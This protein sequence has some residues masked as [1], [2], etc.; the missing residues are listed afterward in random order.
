MTSSE[1]MIA[2]TAL[3]ATCAPN[4][5]P[6]VWFANECGFTPKAFPRTPWTRC[7]STVGI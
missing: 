2:I 3:R 4:V 7:A 6:T 5:G 1:K